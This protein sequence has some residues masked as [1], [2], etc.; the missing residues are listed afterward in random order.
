MNKFDEIREYKRM[1]DEGLI[2]EKDFQLKKHVLLDLPF[3]EKENIQTLNERLEEDGLHFD[4]TNTK[5]ESRIIKK[6][7]N[8]VVFVSVIVIVVII[9]SAIT[10]T[11]FSKHNNK[12]AG[13]TPNHNQEVAS[14]AELATFSGTYIHS[15]G[16]G[17]W[18]QE[19]V[20]DDKGHFTIDF[21]DSDMGDTGRDYPNGTTYKCSGKGVFSDIEKIDDKTYC[22][23]LS[24]LTIKTPTETSEIIDGIKYVYTDLYDISEGDE[25]YLYKENSSIGSLPQD[26]IDWVRWAWEYDDPNAEKLPYKG[27]YD[28]SSRIGLISYPMQ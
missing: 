12:E 26:Y 16:A 19:L 27:L 22:L 4:Y 24:E 9:M 20:L 21:H 25:F 15:S 11:L 13:N 23:H 7:T 14:A 2:S 17:A 5:S 1:L 10:I 8:H 18:S 3:D 6:R 28:N